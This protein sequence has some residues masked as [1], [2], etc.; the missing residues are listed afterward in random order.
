MQLLKVYFVGTLNDLLIL[1]TLLVNL[2][3]NDRAKTEKHLHAHHTCDA[4]LCQWIYTGFKGAVVKLVIMQ[5]C[6]NNGRKCRVS[7]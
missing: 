4:E 7:R 3:S 5:Q 1:K 2:P 6:A